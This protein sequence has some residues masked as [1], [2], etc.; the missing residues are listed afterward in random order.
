[1]NII[2]KG[3]L[4]TTL[5][6]TALATTPAMARGYHGHGRGDDTAAIAIGAGILGIAIG[7]IVASSGNRD[8][9]YDDG[10]YGNGYYG[11]GYY[12]NNWQYRDGYYWDHDGRRY[13]RNAWQRYNRDYRG[14]AD[15]NRNYNGREGYGDYRNGR[16]SQGDYRRGYD[17]DSGMY[18]RGY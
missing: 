7:A 5:A 11:Y 4:A 16:D 6:A 10:Y 17:R 3:I 8:R 12:G 14:R 2:R 1:M 18:R 15:N 9:G 13:D